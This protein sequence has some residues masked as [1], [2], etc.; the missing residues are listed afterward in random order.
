MPA[1]ALALLVPVHLDALYVEHQHSVVAPMADFSR[2]PYF[3]GK[4]DINAGTPWVGEAIA[5]RPFQEDTHRLQPGMHLHWA[6][7]DALCRALK[8]DDGAIRFPGVPDRWMVT[9]GVE[10]GGIRTPERRWL[11]ESN[12][13]HP[14]DPDQERAPPNAV[15]YPYPTNLQVQPGQQPYRYLGRA[16]PLNEVRSGK[17]EYLSEPLTALG[18]GQPSFSA[19]YPN[20]HSVFGFHDE[21]LIAPF[22]EGLYYEVIGWYHTPDYDAFRQLVLSAPPHVA[23]IGPKA[24]EEALAAMGWKAPLPPTSLAPS[25]VCQAR[26][27][28]PAGPA[29]A[30][31]ELLSPAVTIGNTTAEAISAYLAAS[32]ALLNPK[33][34]SEIEDQ[35]E[36][37]LLSSSLDHREVDIA[38]KFEEARHEQGFNTT[39]PTYLWAIRP[40]SPKAT[41]AEAELWPNA[42][43]LLDQLNE[44]QKSYDAAHEELR[45]RRMQLAAD[46][47]KYMY[48]AYAHEGTLEDYP[49]PDLVRPLI[50]RELSPLAKLIA[51]TGEV[52]FSPQQMLELAPGNKGPLAVRLVRKWAELRQA[53]LSHEP[54]F[55]LQRVVAPSFFQPSEPV[56]LLTGTAAHATDRYRRA[57]HDGLE[58]T[59]LALED[60][61]ESSV[62]AIELHLGQNKAWEERAWSGPPWHP[63]LLEWEV[64]MRPYKHLSNQTE[65]GAY[66]PDF[67]VRNFTLLRNDVDLSSRSA[68]P[69]LC[70]DSHRYSGSSLLTPHG[71]DAYLARLKEYLDREDAARSLAPAERSRAPLSDETRRRLVQLLETLR[72]SYSMAQSLSGFNNAL[73][74][75]RQTL[76]LPIAEPIGFQE[77]R[78]FAARVAKVLGGPVH[79]SPQ[80]AHGFSPI[81]AGELRLLRLRL[82]DTF[83]QTIDLDCETTTARSAETL[84]L[85]APGFAVMVPPRIVQAS[86]L[87][88]RWLA[89]GEDIESNSHP[90]TSPVCGWVVANHIDRGLFIYDASGEALGYLETA[91]TKVRW[92][93]MPGHPKP[94]LVLNEDIEDPLLRKMVS[95]FLQVR[96]SYFETFLSDLEAAQDRIEPE[97]AGEALLMGRP[98]ALVRA[99][100]ALRLEEPPAVHQGWHELLDDLS[101]PA[102]STDE[103]TSIRF[104]LRLGDQDQLGDGVAVYWE[105][106]DEGYVI[107]NYDPPDD[108]T[109]DPKDRACDFLYLKPN[110]RPLE[111]S[112]LVD[113][114]AAVH[115]SMGILPTKA[116][117]I[118]PQYYQDVLPR[119]EAS[120]LAAPLLVDRHEHGPIELPVMDEP[121]KTWAFV[122]AGDLAKN[123]P[124]WDEPRAVRPAAADAPFKAPV[125]I[126]EGWL[127]LSQTALL[128]SKA[129]DHSDD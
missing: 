54:A 77:D 53:L 109:V 1:P 35:L 68:Q 102:R 95:F 101:K 27:T 48:C 64:A 91:G 57:R 89:A 61:P 85:R 28:L 87:R 16:L 94:V 72:V 3:N 43:L 38:A 20:C 34:K 5:S 49:D 81:R 111:V 9:R 36:A 129:G 120:F 12:Y 62:Q 123:E 115:A 126:R 121:G 22:R 4:R 127:R 2:L 103:L 117:T 17:P 97:D 31:P 84:P 19:F 55:V 125:A 46:W 82:V 37:V 110:A 59:W 30:R 56:V 40:N 79:R 98:L 100:L 75:T 6:L 60:S 41:E 67:I 52:R 44:L 14:A 78:D 29:P 116:I 25:V 71:I 42:A 80:P 33:L 70:H 21:E 26:L 99:S 119:L 118:P 15:T 18:Y 8:S 76:H 124:R 104:P 128:E 105:R 13:L 92:C 93:P 23:K 32:G 63:F 96:T 112:M 24:F 122:T 113:P 50:E 73:L 83:G 69:A 86:Q 107:P 51:D 7:P 58:C 106:L 88:F 74:M 10:V 47:H 108:L 114:R 45:S 11:V 90:H 65:E 66:H 39:P